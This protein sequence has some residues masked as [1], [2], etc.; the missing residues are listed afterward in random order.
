MF[1][2]CREKKWVTIGDSTMKIFKWVPVS[3]L[4]QTPVSR[5]KLVV[6]NENDSN[7]NGSSNPNKENLNEKANDKSNLSALI[8]EDSTMGFS[9]N[10]MDESSAAEK[11]ETSGAPTNGVET[12]VLNGEN[13]SDAQF[14][15]SK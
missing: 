8:K 13:S 1:S 15:D 5:P 4:E 12:S 11:M 10:S 3:S 7:S 2:P 14:P 9:E 6:S